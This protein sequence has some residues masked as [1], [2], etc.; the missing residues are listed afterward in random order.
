MTALVGLLTAFSGCKKNEPNSPY[1]EQQRKAF[2]IFKGVW[3]DYQYSHL[4]GGVFEPDYIVFGS[5]FEEPKKVMESSY[6][7]GE[8]VA[9]E[10]QGECVYR[11][12]YVGT[13]SYEE[14][15]CHYNVSPKADYL[16]L[17]EISTGNRYKRF[18]M[19]IKNET[20]IT[21]QSPDMTLPYVFKKIQ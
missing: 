7:N 19:D 16:E 1:T 3:A 8:T 13:N 17:Y 6:M 11:D 2:A 21:L 9:Y 10:A 4:G 15:H 5:H 20:T 12:Y 14:T 18:Y